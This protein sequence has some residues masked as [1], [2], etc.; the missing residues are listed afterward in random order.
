M[1]RESLLRSGGGGDIEASS[2]PPPVS[3][4]SRGVASTVGGDD[5]GYGSDGYH[6][7]KGSKRLPGVGEYDGIFPSSRRRISGK[8][9]NKSY[10]FKLVQGDADTW[11]EYTILVLIVINVVLFAAATVDNWYEDYTF[12]FELVEGISIIIFT[13]EYILRI[14]LLKAE[15][16][17]RAFGLMGE[18]LQ[19]NINLLIATTVYAGILLILAASALFFTESRGPLK[20]TFTSVPAAMYPALLMLTGNMP[21]LAMSVTTLGRFVTSF[22][23]LIAVAVFAVPTGI[24][25]SGFVKALQK[26][27][28]RE[29]TVDVDV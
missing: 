29:F 17:M 6:D 5:G 3:S 13:I 8:D 25:G 27:E 20:H 21:D 14:W 1:S 23:A 28:G 7:S 22:I 19:E 15:K 18:V 11:F 9:P 24:I 16:Y 12:E 26:A 10:I 2:P 4:S